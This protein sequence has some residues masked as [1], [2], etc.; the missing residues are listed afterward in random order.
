M[1]N[2]N[3]F[4]PLRRD[5][6]MECF[7]GLAPHVAVKRLNRWIKGDKELS[8]LLTL[9]NYKPRSR[10]LTSRQVRIIRQYI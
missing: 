4:R 9:Y 10:R 1:T 7:P 8:C 2:T 5:V 3:F 6:A